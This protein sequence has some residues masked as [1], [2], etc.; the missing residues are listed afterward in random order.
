MK[1]TY[2]YI[3]HKVLTVGDALRVCGQ[4]QKKKANWNGKMVPN[5]WSFFLAHQESENL[6]AC[7]NA[8]D[9]RD[10]PCCVHFVAM[11]TRTPLPSLNSD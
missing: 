2:R 6:E 5:T 11:M 4:G 10:Y 8:I 7:H 1:A 9:T 3:V